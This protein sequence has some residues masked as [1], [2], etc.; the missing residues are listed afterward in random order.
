MLPLRCGAR[1]SAARVRRPRS[2]PGR[3]RFAADS[4]VVRDVLNLRWGVLGV[5]AAA[6]CAT[7]AAAAAAAAAA[8]A[9][10]SAAASAILRAFALVLIAPVASAVQICGAAGLRGGGCG[11][12]VSAAD[13]VFPESVAS[14]LDMC[15]RSSSTIL[16]FMKYERE[17]EL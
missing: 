13:R 14:S 4:G 10:T 6:A 5:R 8:S 1:L 15:L 3:L 16:R 9:A 7:A 11:A 12:R 17:K 2:Q